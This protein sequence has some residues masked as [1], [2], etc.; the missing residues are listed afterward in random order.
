MRV[1]ELPSTFQLLQR[2][3]TVLVV[4]PAARATALSALE[5]HGSLFAFAAASSQAERL[6]GR[7]P[8]YS[9]PAPG[10]RWVVRHYRRGGAV[11]RWLG[12]RYLAAGAPRPL[13]ELRTSEELRRR[14]VESPRVMAAAIYP[15]GLFYRADI[16]T[17]WIPNSTDL[18]EALFGPDEVKGEDRTLACAAAGRLIREMH[19]V[20]VIHPDLNLKNILIEWSWTPPRP[21]LLDLDRVRIARRVSPRRRRAMLARFWRSARKWE[22]KTDRKLTADERAAFEA[23]YAG[24]AAEVTMA[25]PVSEHT[26]TYTRADH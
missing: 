4:V 15:A 24:G 9:V 26:H 18:A 2:G 17:L 8:V 7:G 1:P 22:E 19:E 25:V 14:G 6:S 23:G 3:S 16:A 20:G 5:S 12:D 10:G 11:A 21:Y 13:R